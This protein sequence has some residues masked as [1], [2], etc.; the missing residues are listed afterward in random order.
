MCQL[1]IPL[2]YKQARTRDE[3]DELL[4]AAEVDDFDEYD[5]DDFMAFVGMGQING[6]HEEYGLQSGVNYVVDSLV[7]FM[8]VMM[9]GA[10]V[11]YYKGKE[12]ADKYQFDD[13]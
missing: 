5:A 3:Y 4:K 8:V 6:N 12:A 11:Y 7:I 2:I 9:I 13:E 10:S 1:V